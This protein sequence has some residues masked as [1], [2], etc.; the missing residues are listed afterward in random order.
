MVTKENENSLI[1]CHHCVNVCGFRGK[2]CYN[3]FNTADIT[4]KYSQL[5]CTNKHKYDSMKASKRHIIH[6]N[7]D[8]CVWTRQ[9][10][11]FFFILFLIVG[12]KIMS[13][14]LLL[15]VLSL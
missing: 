9:P 2:Q 12:S 7:L 4:V 11:F 10:L 15:G 14:F 1:A 3:H 13:G 8:I 5:S 6:L